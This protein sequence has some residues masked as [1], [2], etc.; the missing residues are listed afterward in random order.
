MVAEW[1]FWLDLLLILALA[2]LPRFCVKVLWQQFF[3]SDIQIAREA[4]I[5]GYGSCRIEQGVEL[6][7]VSHSPE[8]VQPHH[9]TVSHWTRTL[10]ECRNSSR[11]LLQFSSKLFPLLKVLCGDALKNNCKRADCIHRWKQYYFSLQY[12]A[13][14]THLYWIPIGNGHLYAIQLRNN[15]FYFLKISS[16]RLRV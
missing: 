3:P 7:E 2:L 8:P 9:S 15:Y 1:R 6:S 10:T 16:R 11:N 4:E 13:C 5:R 14:A 12:T